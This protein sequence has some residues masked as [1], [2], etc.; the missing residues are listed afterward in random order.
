M[1]EVLLGKSR[2]RSGLVDFQKSNLVVRRIERSIVHRHWRTFTSGCWTL[3]VET[4]SMVARVIHGVRPLS[5][6]IG[7]DPS[8]LQSNLIRLNF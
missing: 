1:C 5:N 4:V 3:G 6:Q 8:E 7:S 2:S